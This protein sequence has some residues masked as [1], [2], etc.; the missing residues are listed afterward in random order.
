MSE[1]P[2]T[3]PVGG[4]AWRKLSACSVLKSIKLF[5][6]IPDELYDETARLREQCQDLRTR[7]N[8]S[9]E[10]LRARCF[11]P[12]SPCGSLTRNGKPSRF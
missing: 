7:V 2:T 3:R 10:A 6:V 5:A 1:L 4:L 11:I 12:L 9:R 8:L